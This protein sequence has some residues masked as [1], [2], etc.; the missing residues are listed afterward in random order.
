MLNGWESS[1]LSLCSGRLWMCCSFW[2]CLNCVVLWL[3]G[4]I[5]EDPNESAWIWLDHS[6]GVSSY[7][8]CRQWRCWSFMFPLTNERIVCVCL[9]ALILFFFFVQFVRFYL[10][11]TIKS[12]SCIPRW[13][14]LLDWCSGDINRMRWFVFFRANSLWD[15]NM[16]TCF[17]AFYISARVSILHL[18][19]YLTLLLTW[20]NAGS[21]LDIIGSSG[22]PLFLCI[23][24]ARSVLGRDISPGKYLYRMSLFNQPNKF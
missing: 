11:F 12:F 3:E 9:I 10:D 14:S 6:E 16:I 18:F 24:T 21:L 17:C 8:L 22:P 7:E 15:T 19:K 13:D 5:G 4:S 20:G 1:T 2:L 23:H